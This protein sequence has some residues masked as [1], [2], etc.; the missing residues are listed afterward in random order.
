MHRMASSWCRSTAGP[1]ECSV[2]LIVRA[3]LEE[4][5]GSEVDRAVRALFLCLRHTSAA[6]AC[7]TY[8]A[9][10]SCGLLVAVSSPHPARVEH[11]F[12]Q[13]NEQ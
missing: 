12:I 5:A 7:D 1:N 3:S 11:S 4:W 8:I 6:V 9:P 10:A 13:L 2:V